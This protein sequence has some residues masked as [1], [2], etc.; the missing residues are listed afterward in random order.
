MPAMTLKASMELD[1]AGRLPNYI[2]ASSG[3]RK[4]CTVQT[5]E[6]MFLPLKARIFMSNIEGLV[7]LVKYSHI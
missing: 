2:I 4:L 5:S 3:R 7:K 1:E 6:I